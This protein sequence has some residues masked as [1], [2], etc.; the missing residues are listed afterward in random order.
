[1]SSETEEGQRLSQ[2][3]LKRI[4]QGTGTIKACRKYENPTEFPETHKLW[5]DTNRRPTIRDVDDQA[6]F[7]RIHPIPFLAEIPAD[8][9]DRDLPRKLLIEA[10]G[11]LAWAIEGARLWFKD[12]LCRPP[13]VEKATEEWRDEDDQL[14]RF[15]EDCCVVGEHFRVP[16]ASIYAAYRKWS[17]ENG[18]QP[19]TNTMFGRKVARRGY[20]KEHDRR[21][22]AY[23]GIGLQA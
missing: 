5:L 19:M 16:A 20:R 9:M 1:M 17:E 3:K 10:E 15:I 13:E 12:G 23:L 22:W 21:G 18:D 2:A 7:N 6:T 4:T 11:I 8:K 14:K